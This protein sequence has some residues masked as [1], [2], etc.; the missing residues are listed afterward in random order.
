[1]DTP[2]PPFRPHRIQLVGH[3]NLGIIPAR[4]DGPWL[5]LEDGTRHGPCAV[6]SAQPVAEAK[7]SRGALVWVTLPGIDLWHYLQAEGH[8]HPTYG[9]SHN[10]CIKWTQGG[11][12]IVYDRRCPDLPAAI[13]QITT[14]ARDDGYEVPPWSGEPAAPVEPQPEPVP[15]PV[16]TWGGHTD[17]IAWGGGECPVDA[18]AHVGL[19]FRDG[20]SG[21]F[22]RTDALRWG[23]T[24]GGGDII[25]Y[26]IVKPAPKDRTV[27]DPDDIRQGDRHT[28][29]NGSRGRVLCVHD[30]WIAYVDRLPVVHSGARIVSVEPFDD[31]PF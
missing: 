9:A 21:S 23:H 19:A 29:E 4:F 31:I 3:H 10:Q 6:F 20:G 17:W 8:K 15:A 12:G 5:E 18:D 1:M 13:A 14:W 16:G 24:N 28:F 26:R 2:L 11:Y 27:Y 30:G 7:A 25:A 22:Y